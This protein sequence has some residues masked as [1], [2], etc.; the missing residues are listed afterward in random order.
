MTSN[1]TTTSSGVT[2]RDGEIETKSERQR[3]GQKHQDLIADSWSFIKEMSLKLNTIDVDH[4]QVHVVELPLDTLISD[5]LLMAH[6]T[7]GTII[8][9]AQRY[10]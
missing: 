9:A 3:Q 4:N 7:T 1:Q 8:S 2:E 10:P 6:K 5:L